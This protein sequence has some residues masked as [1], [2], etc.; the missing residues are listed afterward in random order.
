M[1]TYY[2]VVEIDN[3]GNETCLITTADIVIALMLK[4]RMEETKP[5]NTYRID[6]HWEK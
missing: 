6:T 5:E 1:R 2:E 4:D 3:E